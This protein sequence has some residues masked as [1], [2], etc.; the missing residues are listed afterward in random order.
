MTLGSEWLALT[1]TFNSILFVQDVY[2]VH[3][4][5]LCVYT[6]TPVCVFL[7]PSCAVSNVKKVYLELGGKSLHHLQ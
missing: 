4:L 5:S 1:L 3:Y 7:Y 6:L 2:A